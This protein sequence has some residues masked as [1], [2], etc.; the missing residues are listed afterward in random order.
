MPEV[1]L[2]HAIEKQRRLP[3][4]RLEGTAFGLDFEGEVFRYHRTVGVFSSEVL[5]E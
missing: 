4:G 5:D 1:R 3:S 2:R